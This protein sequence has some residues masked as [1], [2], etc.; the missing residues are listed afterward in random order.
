MRHRR[1]LFVSQPNPNQNIATDGVPRGESR[2]SK[3]CFGYSSYALKYV[4]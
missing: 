3:V 2:G 1:D 4:L